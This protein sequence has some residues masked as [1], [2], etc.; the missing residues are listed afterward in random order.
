VTSDAADVAKR[1]KTRFLF[2]RGDFIRNEKI[3]LAL[4][5]FGYRAAAIDLQRL[6]RIRFSFYPKQLARM[7]SVVSQLLST[8]ARVPAPDRISH[9]GLRRNTIAAP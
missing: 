4:D 7:K 2:F 9:P 3:L 5:R 6:N 8:R 1:L